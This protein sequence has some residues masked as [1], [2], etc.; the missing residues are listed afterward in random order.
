MIEK[1][2]NERME[3]R[4]NSSEILLR[5]TVLSFLSLPLSPCQYIT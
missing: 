5:W 2:R 1:E 3:G 4:N